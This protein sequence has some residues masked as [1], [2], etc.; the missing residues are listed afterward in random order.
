MSLLQT[1]FLFPAI[2][3]HN[4]VLLKRLK[5]HI[6]DFKMIPELGSKSQKKSQCCL[7]SALLAA[8]GCMWPKIFGPPPD[9]S[10]H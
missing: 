5:P 10:L 4:Y 3:F 9:L 1:Y 2:L 6:K 8:N 7:R